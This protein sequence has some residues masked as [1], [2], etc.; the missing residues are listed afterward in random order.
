MGP[1]CACGCGETLPQGSTRAYKRGHKRRVIEA[2]NKVLAGQFAVGA[3]EIASE[4]E[5]PIFK[6]AAEVENDPE[7]AIYRKGTKQGRAPLRINQAVRRDVEGKIGFMLLA[8]G[9]A[10]QL[11]DPICGTVLLEQT[12]E[13]AAKLTP[14]LCQSSAVVEWFQKGTSIMMYV[15]LLMALAPVASTFY[16]H[17]LSRVPEVNPPVA[18]DDS[19]YG[20]RG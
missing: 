6:M 15:D 19:Y 20:V 12:P 9:N 2:E 4:T 14:I 7:P 11:A 13:L 1:E 18:F 8:T 10:W 17:H 16:R 3:D 5:S